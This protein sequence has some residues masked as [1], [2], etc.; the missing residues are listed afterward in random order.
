M[1]ELTAFRHAPVPL[2]EREAELLSQADLVF[3][4]GP[5]LYESK[6]DRHPDV[7]LF[8]SGVDQEHFARGLDPDLQVPEELARLP[9]PVVGFYGVIDE[10][11][12]L[13]LLVAA[14]DQR[15]DRSWVMIG[16]FMKIEL[17]ALPRRPNLHYLGKQEYRDLPAFLKGFDVAMM[18]FAVNES[19]RFISPT[20]T[21]EY[22]AAHKPIV[23]T[24]I[25]DVISLY[26]SVVRFA[27]DAEGFVAQVEAA[28]GESPQ[29][30]EERVRIANQL[31]GRYSWDTIASE[32]RGLIGDR[33]G[34]KISG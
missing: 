18:P 15:P 16:P 23:S 13:A 14:A 8:P 21:L 12:D 7:H 30:R 20:K 27:D 5:S 17:D 33:L 28:L 24:A 2:R 25:P 4:G 1:D 22:M 11:T 34:T 9:R 31:L 10:R 6:R 19:T 29:E 26:G 3:G 32:I